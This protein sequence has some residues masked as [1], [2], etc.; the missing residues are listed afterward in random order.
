MNASFT[1][2]TI[3]VSAQFTLT[4]GLISPLDYRMKSRDKS[5]RSGIPKNRSAGKYSTFGTYL[6]L[7]MNQQN[8]M[9]IPVEH[10]IHFHYWP[11]SLES[12][13]QWFSNLF[14]TRTHLLRLTNCRN[15]MKVILSWKW[16]CGRKGYHRT[17]KI[18]APPYD[19]IKSIQFIN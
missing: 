7:S 9:K 4:A 17:W 19:Q 5:V 8:I 3:K 13:R 10:E 1:W 6:L 16:C 11:R 18:L 2:W 15:P 14:D 12:L